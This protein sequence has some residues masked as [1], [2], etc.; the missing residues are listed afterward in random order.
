MIQAL[1]VSFGGADGPTMTTIP[2]QINSAAA[3]APR[4]QVMWAFAT[5][6]VHRGRALDSPRGRR[7]AFLGRRVPLQS[8]MLL[9][10]ARRFRSRESP[11]AARLQTGRPFP[12]YCTGRR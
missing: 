8:R 12:R 11:A 10:P 2:T 4:W 5:R 3:N 7:A 6:R 1:G 9:V